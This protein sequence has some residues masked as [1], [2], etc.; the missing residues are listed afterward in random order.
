M[1]GKFTTKD[2]ARC[3]HY[4]RFFKQLTL[5]EANLIFWSLFVFVLTLMCI[6][7]IQ[8]HKSNN[9]TERLKSN[10]NASPRHKRR[11]HRRRIHY[12][13][14]ASLCF[15]LAF[16]S[17]LFEVFAAFNIEYCYGE[18]LIQ[19]YWGFWSVLQVGSL[20]AILGV[21]L[22]FWI[23]LGNVQTPSWAVALGTP[24]LVF[25]ALGWIIR[26]IG[27]SWRMRGKVDGDGTDDEEGGSGDEEEGGEGD[28]EK[29]ESWAER[30]I[31]WAP[32]Q[33]PGRREKKE[34]ELDRVRTV[35]ST[36]ISDMEFASRTTTL[37][38]TPAQPGDIR[39]SP[40]Y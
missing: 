1:T 12:L 34:L 38:T 11:I 27:K 6:S 17:I 32:D 28:A 26:H 23:V 24:V 29:R 8:H 2:P 5:T 37:Y 18:D 14:I 20:I 22:Q 35:R 10:P 40:T 25:A 3:A 15:I 7:S 19:L 36:D 9:L 13:S 30:C 4:A 21:M 16:T 31:R 33:E 39:R